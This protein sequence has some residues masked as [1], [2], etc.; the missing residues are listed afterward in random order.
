MASQPGRDA[1]GLEWLADRLRVVCRGAFRRS[2]R[3]SRGSVV[4][5]AML[6][7]DRRGLRWAMRVGPLAVLWVP[8]VV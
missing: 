4:L 5:S 1:A 8:A 6:I 3:S 7:A 2:G